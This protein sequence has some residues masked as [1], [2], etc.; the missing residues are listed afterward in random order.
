MGKLL[1]SVGLSFSLMSGS[2]ISGVVADELPIEPVPNVEVL[3]KE[4]SKDWVFA[5]DLHFNSILDG[6]VVLLDVAT[7]TRQYKGAIGAAQMASFIQGAMR[8][9]LYVTETFHDRGSR[10]KRI[11]VLTIY[12]QENMAPIEEVILPGGK[13]SQSVIQE[14]SMQ[15]TGNEKF[16][17]VFN[18]TPAASVT[19]IDLDSRKIVSDVDMPGC[20][21][22]YPLG[23]QAFG[24]LCGNGTMVS[25]TL[26]DAGKATRG[27]TTKPFND[28]DADP[29]FM[30]NARL[31][32]HGYFPSF[33]GAIQAI[34]MSGNVPVVENRWSIAGDT[35]AP[36]GW[37]PSGWQIIAGGETTGELY[38]LMQEGAGHGDHKSG[39]MEVWVFDPIAKKLTRRI[40]LKTWGVSIEV[41]NGSSAYLTVSN[42]ESDLDVYEA[43]TGK[44]VR[45][46]GGGFA[47][48]AF[49]LHAVK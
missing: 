30:K 18:F 13:R 36:S 40:P 19:V 24:T 27:E 26:D 25:F 22:I 47:Q 39:G 12:D 5:H 23:E 9:E 7:D 1:L 14:A 46:I 37:L 10:G 28:L 11:D 35:G 15:L 4:Y 32:T 44:F 34:N 31:G 38:V 29:L 41:T 2:M 45:T 16:L 3:P 8:P 6:K 48:N 42:A 17:L 21:L 20:S 33:G 49:L 43:K